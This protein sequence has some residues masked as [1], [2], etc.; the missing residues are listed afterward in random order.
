M[1]NYIRLIAGFICL[2]SVVSCDGFFK[3]D[4]YDGPNAQI[5]GAF[6]DSETKENIPLETAHNITTMSFWGW[7]FEVDEP[8]GRMVVTQLGWD[9]E[10]EQQWYPKFDGT[11]TNNIV[12]AGKYKFS[13]KEMPIYQPENAEFEIKEGANTVNFDVLP[14]GRIYDLNLSYDAAAKKYVAKFKVEVTDPT[15]A[16][17]IT[18]IKFAASTQKHVGCKLLN[19]AAND[20]G[21]KLAAVSANWWEPASLEADKEYTLYI[22]TTSPANAELFKYENRPI[23]LRVGAIVRD[24]STYN[25]QQAYNLSGIY[26]VSADKTISTTPE[27]F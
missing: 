7:T 20:P 18:E 16:N 23:Y 1:K 10:A 15:K 6:I 22:D 9:A 26:K 3:L 13:A 17:M 19:M 5:T 11:Y 12:F 25:T 21:A 4:N 14:F 27:T 8:Y 24:A 2:A